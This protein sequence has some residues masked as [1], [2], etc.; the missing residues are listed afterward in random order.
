MQEAIE[1]V[2]KRPLKWKFIVDAEARAPTP[3]P[4]GD[5]NLAEAALEVF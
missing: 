1:S 5:V 2:F 4:A 3:A